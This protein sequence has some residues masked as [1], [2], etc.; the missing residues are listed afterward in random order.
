[1]MV[2]WTKAV[3]VGFPSLVRIAYKYLRVGQG[4]R[5]TTS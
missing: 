1:M 4:S 5:P 3:W 2:A